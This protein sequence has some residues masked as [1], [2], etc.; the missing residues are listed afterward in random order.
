MCS[1][2]Y[3]EKPGGR[4]VKTRGFYATNLIRLFVNY[5]FKVLIT[6]A[7]LMATIGIFLSYAVS[8]IMSFGA[9]DTMSLVQVLFTAFLIYV[10]NKSAPKIASVLATGQPSLGGADFLN[11]GR[12]LA[13][14]ARTAGHIAQS[15]GRVAQGAG[16]TAVNAAAAGV[17]TAA[18]VGSAF[19]AV[20]G[21]DDGVNAGVK[22]GASFLA[23][24]AGSAIGRSAAQLLTGTKISQGNDRFGVGSYNSNAAEAG[25]THGD[26]GTTS[27]MDSIKIAK[28]L[29]KAFGAGKQA[30]TTKKDNKDSGGGKTKTGE[31]NPNQ[32]SSTL[33]DNANDK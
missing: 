9:S 18:A 25:K 11:A 19:K 4:K 26:R 3:F 7:V 32:F 5:F 29:G 16:R 14:G 23:K 20:G 27:G 33:K 21:G 1:D 8:M 31:N 28:E 2:F 24:S 12:S 6:M 15:G 17:G 22:A 10:I 13:Q 30:E